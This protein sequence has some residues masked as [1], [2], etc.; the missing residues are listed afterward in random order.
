MS[1][2]TS[3]RESTTSVENAFL[4]LA[5]EIRR[6]VDGPAGWPRQQGQTV[7]QLALLRGGIAKCC[8]DPSV[9]EWLRVRGCACHDK[10]AVHL[11]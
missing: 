3:A 10:W 7:V 5:D 8:R 4:V 2:E 6:R 1:A 9:A 11:R